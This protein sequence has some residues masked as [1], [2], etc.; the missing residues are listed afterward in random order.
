MKHGFYAKEK[1]KQNRIQA[2]IILGALAVI[3]LSLFI[4]WKTGVY[5][6]TIFTL[7]IVLSIIAP[8]ID[9]PSLKK[10]G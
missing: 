4:S 8:F 5:L 10:S 7:P 9:T 2:L 3:L 6:I 1:R